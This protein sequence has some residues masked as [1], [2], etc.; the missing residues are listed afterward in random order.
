MRHSEPWRKREVSSGQGH[1]RARD[2]TFSRNT[3][4]PATRTGVPDIAAY[5][6]NL[7]YALHN[8]ADAT[9]DTAAQAESVSHQRAA[10]AAT[11]PGDPDRAP[12]LFTLASGLRDLHGR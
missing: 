7:A 6:N 5:H 2:S 12:Y 8:L 11:D 3:S 10:V 4:A 1:W 9:A